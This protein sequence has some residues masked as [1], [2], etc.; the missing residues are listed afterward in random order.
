MFRTIMWP[1]MYTLIKDAK[2]VMHSNAVLP[3]LTG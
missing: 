2:S 3:D 1:H